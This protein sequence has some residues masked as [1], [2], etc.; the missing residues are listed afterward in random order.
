[1]LDPND[2]AR[3]KSTETEHPQKYIKVVTIGT[4]EKDHSSD[5]C[6]YI[7]AKIDCLLDCATNTG[8]LG[9]QIHQSLLGYSTATTTRAIAETLRIIDT[10]IKYYMAQRFPQVQQP[11]ESDSEEYKNKSNNP[12]TAQAKSTV[13]KKPKVL[14]PTTP[15]YHQTLQSRIVFNPPPET[16]SE[17]PRTPGNPHSWNQHNW[18][19]LLREYGLLFGNLTLA[20][21]QTEGNPSTW[22]Q[23]PAQNLA[24]SASP[25]I[26]ETTIL[27]PIGLSNKGKQPVLAPGEHSNTRTPIPL[28]I[29]SNTPPINRI[30]AYQDIA[31]LEKFS[32]EEDNA[33]SWIADAKKTI[34]AN[35][36]N[37]DHTVQALLFFLT[38]TANSWYQS[39]VEKP[40]SFTE[41]KLAFLQYF[42]H[43]AVTTYLRQF[44]QI[45]YQI[46]AI[47]RDYYIMAQVLNQFIKELQSSILRSVRLHHPTSLQDTVTL[48]RNF[49]SVEQEVNHTQAVNLAIN[50]TSDINA[51]ITQL[52]KITTTADTHSNRTINNSNN[53]R[54][55]IPTTATTAKNLDT[56]PVTA[57]ERSWTKIKET[58]TSNPDIS[59][60]CPAQSQPT[61]TGYL[62]QAFYLGLME[63]QGFDKS[64]PM[65]RGDIKR[66]SQPSKQTKSNILPATITEDTTLAA[67]FLFDI[68]NLNTHSLFSGA[69]I[70]QDK[71]IT[72]LYTDTRVRGIDI[73]LILDSGSADS[74]ITKQLMDQLGEIDNFP[75]KINE[76]QIPTKVL[77]MEATQYQAL[78]GNNWLSK[79]NATL[80]WNTQELQLIHFKN[81]HTEEPLIEFED[82]LMPPTIETYQEKA[83]PKKNP[84]YQ[85]NLF[86]QLSRLIC[87]DCGKKLSTMGACIGNN[88]E[89]SITTK[90]YCR[91]CKW[92]YMPCLACGKI[93]P[94]EELWNNV[95][96]RGGTCDE[97]CQYTILINNWVRKET[98]IED[99][100]KQAF[101]RLDSYPH[102]D[103]EIWKMASTKAE[104][105]TTEEIQEIKDNPWMPKYT[106]P[107]Y[108]KD[109][110]F[111]DDPDAFQNQYQKLA[112]LARNRSKEEVLITEDMSFQDPTEDTKTEQYLADNEKRICLERA[113]NTDAGFDLQYSGQLP[114]I[115]APYSLVKIDL[116]IALEIPV[117]TMVQVVSRSSLAKKGINIKE[118]IIDAGYTENIIMMLQNNSNRP[119]K[120]ESQE[121]IAQAIFL[122]LVKIP[123]LTPVTTQE[124]LGLTAQKINRF[125][126]SGRR[127]IPVNF[128][129]EDSDQVNQKI[130]DQA[131]LFE[132][133]SEICSLANV[134]NLYLPAKA[135]KHF[136]IFIHNLTED[137]IE[138]PK[139]TLVG[140][141]SADNQN[142]EKPQSIPNFT[143]LFLFCDITSQIWNLPKESYLFI[144]KEINK[145]NL[146]NLIL[147]NQYANVFASKNEFG[148]TDIVKHQIDTEDTRPIKQ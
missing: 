148:R 112:Q 123:Q 15:S 31:K 127:N 8:K 49:E 108:P 64:T 98:P 76:I 106:G 70:N 12:V 81:Q 48:V 111:T 142:S 43:E 74:I 115:I 62:N 86:Y 104:D 69:A 68:N 100:W 78:V 22:E 30:M 73:K 125:G 107:D 114:I 52:K 23:P 80:D 135:H 138:I 146:G 117:S 143:Q 60:T 88:E 33:Y 144:P 14:S 110:F 53:L 7:N 61:P 132:A 29:T 128:M 35:G 25:L 85:R 120:I 126:S 91:P 34:T 119:Y 139:G 32:G 50:G 41:F 145:L 44:N 9:E 47:K 102:D 147:L 136:K 134:A 75:F 16:Q 24:E 2:Y 84:N 4:I 55:L 130:Q 20:A 89:W 27:Q 36:W 79:A 5:F 11:V 37:D 97:A 109:D 71:P 99:A 105:A 101:N 19:K 58:H 121:K 103:H 63:D 38:R 72:A 56:L 28:N 122:S 40:T 3:Y 90:Y 67:I 94:D 54:D 65:E 82:T 17:T 93:L 77:I 96:D 42:Y 116:K 137:V 10:D 26:E 113:H 13:N 87:V 39:L 133:S 124:E 118:G 51:K 95:P 57:E 21:G 129:E 6:N 59:K 131:L 1:M 18:T 92:D 141:I 46:L 83:E 45:L 140:S 66:I